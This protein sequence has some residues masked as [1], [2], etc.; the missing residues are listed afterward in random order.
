MR[1]VGGKHRGR[2]IEAPS[3]RDVRPTSDRTR[4]SLFNILAH[5]DWGVALEGA[6]VLDA[7]CGTGA[8]ALE[9]LSR[10]AARALFLD[11]AR[12]SL[13]MARRNADLLGETA[14]CRFVLGDAVKP[15]PAPTAADLAF[16]DPPYAQDLAPPALSGL[17]AAGWL[18][19]GGLACVE[20]GDRD[21]FTPPPGFTLLDERRYSQARLLFLR[22]GAA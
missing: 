14:A 2:R 13:D 22:A 20:V 21:P 7:F 12:P 18:A 1:I 9:A 11:R 16:L 8:L 10:G 4:E 17:N 6:V 5:A 15:P 19:A 3:G